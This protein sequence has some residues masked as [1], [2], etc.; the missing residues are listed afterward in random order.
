MNLSHGIKILVACAV[1]V[2]AMPLVIVML[3]L[4]TDSTNPASA[5]NAGSGGPDWINAALRADAPIPAPYVAWVNQAGRLCGQISPA[6]IAAQLD[7]ESGWNPKAVAHNPA[8]NGGDAKGLAQFQDATWKTWGADYNHNG[9]NSPFDGQDAIYAQGKFMCSNAAWAQQQIA[10]GSIKG[11]VVRI[12]LA[13]YFCGRGCISSHHGV[14]ASGPENAYP[15]QVLSRLPKYAAA[16]SPAGGQWVLPVAAGQYQISSPFG[17]RDGTFHAGVDLAAPRG[18][19]I[20]AAGPGT[21]TVVTCQAGNG[22]CDRDGGAGVSGCGWYV[23]IVHANGYVTRY[24]HM[25]TR[26]IVA[27]GQSIQAGQQIG[28]VGMSGNASGPHLHFEVH[29]SKPATSKN[30]IEPLAFLRQQGLKP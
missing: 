15:K 13:A 7:L 23:E 18:T 19:P 6:L 16:V 24:C 2:V 27:V 25:L 28:V 8:S 26:P 22:S 5:N 9:T 11:D 3:V 10:T 14:P 29:T 12:A 1:G 20:V 17:S 21:V 30:A 4:G